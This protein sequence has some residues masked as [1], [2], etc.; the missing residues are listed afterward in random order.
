MLLRAGRFE[1]HFPRPPMI[2]GILNVTPDSFSDGG[3]FL[4]PAAAADQAFRLESEGADILDLGGESTRPHATP[5]PEEEE[6]RRVRPVLEKLNGRLKIPISI[7]TMKP[8]VV[9]AALELGAV[10]VNDVAAN[11]R[12]GEMWKLVAGTDVAYVVMHMQGTPQTM[13]SAPAYRDVVSE[14]DGFFG[15]RLNQLQGLG[16]RAD[17]VVLDVGLGFGKT[18]EHN[19]RLLAALGEFKKWGRPLL[20]GASRKSF[21]SAV[22]GGGEA[23]ERLPGSLAAACWAWQAGAQILRVHDVAATRQALAMTG[24]ILAGET[25]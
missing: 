3:R 16:V 21:I 13:Q 6:L 7:D 19:L 14:V 2:M 20:V 10:M 15:D 12:P 22:A 25:K 11:R 5:V 1:F 18:A 23:T 4:D 9:R 17:Q 8:G 24:A